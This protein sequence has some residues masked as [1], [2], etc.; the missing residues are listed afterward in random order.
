MC[1][2]PKKPHAQGRLVGT[3]LAVTLRRNRE[4]SLVLVCPGRR[5]LH[6]QGWLAGR[7]PHRLLCVPGKAP[8]P[9]RCRLHSAASGP[10]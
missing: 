6:G 9:F 8:V 4:Y 3:H 2:A 1:R 10:S 5:V 7:C